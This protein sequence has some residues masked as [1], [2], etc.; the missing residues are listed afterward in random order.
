MFQS[1]QGALAIDGSWMIGSYL[2]S[3]FEVGFARLPIGPEGRASMFN[4]LADSIWVGTDNLEESWEW[5]KFLASPE[6]ELI[7]GESGVVFPATPEGVEASL[8]VRA[9]AGV[10]VSAFT[11]QALEEGGTFLFPITDFGGE[12]ATIMSE[13]MDSIALGQTSAEE[14][15]TAANEEVNELFE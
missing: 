5:V 10:D 4:G 12:I 6:C 13:T 8:N 14:A 1:G 2:G 15:L 3:D 9:E 7:V 11:E